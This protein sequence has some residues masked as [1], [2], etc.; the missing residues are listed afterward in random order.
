MQT[1]RYNGIKVGGSVY[2]AS[3]I[4]FPH[5]DLP[6]GWTLDCSSWHVP[7]KHAGVI[8]YKAR[9]RRLIVAVQDGVIIDAENWDMYGNEY[10]YAQQDV[11][12]R[13]E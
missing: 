4:S 13:W 11:E 1:S 12:N 2:G 8:L 3:S 7:Q 6:E 9:S 5:P 10:R